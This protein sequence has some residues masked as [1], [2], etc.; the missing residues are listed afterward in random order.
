MTKRK[1]SLLALGATATLM[2]LAPTAV[3]ADAYGTTAHTCEYVTQSANCGASYSTETAC[4]AATGCAWTGSLCTGDSTTVNN[5]G[6]SFDVPDGHAEKAAAN[7]VQEECAGKATEADCTGSCEWFT[8]SPSG[9]MISEATA[10]EKFSNALTALDEYTSLRC[11][12]QLKTE[13]ACNADS[14]CQWNTAD[15]VCDGNV[16]IDKLL[17]LCD[18]SPASRLTKVSAVVSA[19]FVAALASLA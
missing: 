13:A 1:T 5:L 17:A 4:N 9:C 18:I 16:S 12:V 19:V 11:D 6:A 14:M 10:K 3:N 8:G 15:S 7:A 2:A